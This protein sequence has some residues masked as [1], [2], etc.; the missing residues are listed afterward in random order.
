MALGS[1]T[2]VVNANVYKIYFDSVQASNQYLLATR[3]EAVYKKAQKRVPTG[4]GPV[5]FTM[6]SDDRLLLEFAYTT[7][8]LGSGSSD[9]NKLIESNATSGEV[10]ENNFFLVATDRAGSPVSKTQ[11]MRCK[12]E[13]LRLYSGAEGETLAKLSLVIIDNDIQ[14]S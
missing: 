6:L 8:E 11:T 14:I 9:W 2:A 10:P 12:A 3:K 13:E 4:A 5:Y 7:S 1:K